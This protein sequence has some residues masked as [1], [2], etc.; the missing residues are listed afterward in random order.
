MSQNSNYHSK[1]LLLRIMSA[2]LLL[3]IFISPLLPAQRLH[4]IRFLSQKNTY[5]PLETVTV[6][7]LKPGILHIKDS[8]GR[9]YFN[10]TAESTV[11]FPVAGATGSHT[12]LLVSSK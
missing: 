10:S 7:C 8:K 3:Q 11:S 1:T 9:E 5:K 6:V 12:A 2:I 4:D